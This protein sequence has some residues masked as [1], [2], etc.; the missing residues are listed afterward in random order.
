MDGRLYLGGGVER[1]HKGDPTMISEKNLTKDLKATPRITQKATPRIT[2]KAT[3]GITKDHTKDFTM[4]SEKEFIAGPR[5]KIPLRGTDN[6]ISNLPHQK[7]FS[8][9]SKKSGGKIWRKIPP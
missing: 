4:I 8:A 5:R 7:S 6:E 3:Q 1:P 2:Q 9:L